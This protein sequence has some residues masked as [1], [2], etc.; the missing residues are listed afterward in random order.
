[1]YKNCY[2]KQQKKGNQ[3]VNHK[4]NETLQNKTIYSFLHVLQWPLEKKKIEKNWTI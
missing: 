1:M 2:T 3:A 4:Q